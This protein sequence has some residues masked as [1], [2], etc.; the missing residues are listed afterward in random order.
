M[1]DRVT[2]KERGL[3]KGALRRVFSRSE[4]RKEAIDKASIIYVD[5]TGKTRTKK[6][7]ECSICKKP[8]PQWKIDIDHVFPVVPINK[9]SADMSADELVNGLWCSP[10]NLVAMCEACHN[11]KTKAENAERRKLKKEKNAKSK[12]TS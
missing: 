12:R 9:A 2:K 10:N 6:W 8:T 11:G 4:L 7:C 1:N 3:I 5:P